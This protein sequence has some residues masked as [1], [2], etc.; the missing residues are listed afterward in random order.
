MDGVFLKNSLPSVICGDTFNVTNVFAC[1]PQH[2]GSALV[3]VTHGV[4][5]EDS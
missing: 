2:L 5:D 1:L 3:L 4:V